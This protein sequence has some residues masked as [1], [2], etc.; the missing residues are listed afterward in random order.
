M[1][2]ST[3][4]PILYKISFKLIDMYMLTKLSIYI[5]RSRSYTII[6]YSISSCRHS[7]TMLLRVYRLS[8]PWD[9]RHRGKQCVKFGSDIHVVDS[10]RDSCD[11]NNILAVYGMYNI[12][13]FMN[14]YLISAGRIPRRRTM[15]RQDTNDKESKHYRRRHFEQR[16][17]CDLL[18]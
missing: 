15:R 1:L 12:V 2:S 16:L 17:S 14:P 4:L 18:D 3:V 6:V 5:H 8:W 7:V 9:R 10:D 13:R 11:L